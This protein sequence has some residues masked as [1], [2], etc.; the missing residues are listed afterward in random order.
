VND[1][2]TFP[3]KLNPSINSKMTDKMIQP[4][5]RRG[6]AGGG[7]VITGGGV[8]NGGGAPGEENEFSITCAN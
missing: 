5:L 4:Q 2:T 8:L 3:I 6:L 7:G 1:C